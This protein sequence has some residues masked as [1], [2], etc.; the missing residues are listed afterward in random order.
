M[1]GA[2]IIG[3]AM[4]LVCLVIQCVALA[5]VLRQMQSLEQSRLSFRSWPGAVLVLSVVTIIILAGNLTQIA[6][7]ASLFVYLGEFNDFMT[8]FYHSVVNFSTLG[9]GDMVMS[10]KNRLLGALEALNGVLM[11][12]LSTG[13][14]FVVVNEMLDKAWTSRH[15]KR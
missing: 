6:L 11:I 3:I 10:E 4:I 9:Y 2:L 14:M 1:N 13:T 7:W 5:V 12:G 15:E 8:A